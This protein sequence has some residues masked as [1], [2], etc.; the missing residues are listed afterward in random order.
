MKTLIFVCLLAVTATAQQHAV[1][2]FTS[3]EDLEARVD[4]VLA[5]NCDTVYWQKVDMC[6]VSEDDTTGPYTWKDPE[7]GVWYWRRLFHHA[8]LISVAVIPES[9][10]DYFNRR[11]DSTS[12]DSLGN[13]LPKIHNAVVWW[14]ERK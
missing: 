3:A 6:A 12:V 7:T 10:S 1:I 5:V 13:I 14:K 9:I 8:Q 11:I 4:S 2:T